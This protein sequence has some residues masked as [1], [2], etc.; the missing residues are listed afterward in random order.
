MSSALCDAVLQQYQ[1]I[2]SRLYYQ[3]V[4]GCVYYW[5]AVY[6]SAGL[7]F[8]WIPIHRSLRKA[9]GHILV[10]TAVCTHLLVCRCGLYGLC[11]RREYNVGVC[12]VIGIS[13]KTLLFEIS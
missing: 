13:E 8:V 4:Q 9:M 3:C 7:L 11:G 12:A 5:S 1:C 2:I 6:A 10:P